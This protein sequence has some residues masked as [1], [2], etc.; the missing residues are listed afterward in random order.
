MRQRK[1]V[2]DHFFAKVEER[3]IQHN[4][5]EVKGKGDGSSEQDM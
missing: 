4:R 2:I 1:H 3:D 5:Q